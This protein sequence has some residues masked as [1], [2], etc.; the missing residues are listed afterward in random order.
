MCSLNY[1]PL[2]HLHL[3]VFF[4]WDRTDSEKCAL[5]KARLSHRHPSAK[6]PL[7]TSGVCV[8]SK[9]NDTLLRASCF[10]PRA[11]F[12]QYKPELSKKD[13][14][15]KNKIRPKRVK[16]YVFSSNGLACF[17][18]KRC[19]HLRAADA[20]DELPFLHCGIT[21]QTYSCSPAWA[22]ARPT[23]EADR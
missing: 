21:P 10:A 9:S 1:I 17:V 15:K 18:L 6:C 4:L 23:N 19:W 11:D 5:H 2:F 3:D 14:H 20:C 22:I 8:F 16:F 7:K 12:S 13:E